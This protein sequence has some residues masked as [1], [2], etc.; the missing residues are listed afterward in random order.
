MIGPP[1][2]FGPEDLPPPAREKRRLT[3][4][5]LSFFFA[6]EGLRALGAMLAALAG[7]APLPGPPVDALA[8][9]LAPGGGPL[10]PPALAAD[11]I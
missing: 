1:S 2:F 5:P 9:D 3:H 11:D 6:S 4:E 8:P 10:G 7:V